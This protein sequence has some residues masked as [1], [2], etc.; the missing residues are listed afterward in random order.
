MALVFASARGYIFIMDKFAGELDPSVTDQPETRADK[1]APLA[2][3]EAYFLQLNTGKVPESQLDQTAHQLQQLILEHE[4]RH[5]TG[6]KTF[7][8]PDEL[9]L[10][11]KKQ[12]LFKYRIDERD[13]LNLDLS[14][15]EGRMSLNAAAKKLQELIKFRHSQ[16]VNAR[17]MHRNDIAEAMLIRL[18]AL[19]QKQKALD[20][21]VERSATMG[22]GQMVGEA[23]IVMKK[24]PADVVAPTK[25]SRYAKRR[26]NPGKGKWG[27]YDSTSLTSESGA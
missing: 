8:S 12:E 10:L 2:H 21:A 17:E 20:R 5:E 4:A 7:L 23:S 9:S 3:D 11:R 6:S 27:T 24:D 22:T 14:K 1:N 25:P 18:N 26:W 16:I 13:V 15:P 19:R